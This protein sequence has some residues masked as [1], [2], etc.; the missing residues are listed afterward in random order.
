MPWVFRFICFLVFVFFTDVCLAQVITPTLSISRTSGPAPLGVVVSCVG[1]S[2]SDPNVDTIREIYCKWDYGDPTSGTWVDGKSRNED[3]GLVSGHVYDNPG[4][5]TITLT[6]F[7]EAGNQAVTTQQI[8]ADDPLTYYQPASTYCFSNGTDFSFCPYTTAQGA[9]H[10]TTND[11]GVVLSYSG[12][13]RRLILRSGD[14]FVYPSGVGSIDMLGDN[15]ILQS[16]DPTNP[17]SFFI[18]GY[19]CAS[20]NSLV[21]PTG[22]NVTIYGIRFYGPVGNDCSGI[23]ATTLGQDDWADTLPENNLVVYKCE[24]TELDQFTIAG[25]GNGNLFSTNPWQIAYTSGSMFVDNYM[26]D[27]DC[28]NGG[29]QY[30]IYYLVN[31]LFAIIGNRFHNFCNGTGGQHVIRGIADREVVISHN[32][33]INCEGMPSTQRDCLKIHSSTLSDPNKPGQSDYVMI[34]DNIFKPGPYTVWPLAVSAQN[35]FSEELV[36]N[37]IFERNYI[38]VLDNGADIVLLWSVENGAVRNNVAVTAPNDGDVRVF[39]I[40]DDSGTVTATGSWVYNNTCIMDSP[41]TA[42]RAHCVVVEPAHTG[43]VVVGNLMQS[44]GTSV[45][46]DLSGSAVLEGNIMTTNAGVLVDPPSRIEEAKL[47]ESSPAI[48]FYIPSITRN[49]FDAGG[50]IRPVDGPDAD[51]TPQWDAGAWEYGATS[52]KKNVKFRRRGFMLE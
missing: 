6:V 44:S 48:D 12:T 34:Y 29:G 39:F 5:Y 3:M 43:A 52:S 42:S 11:I 36:A 8:V 22:Q 10:V 16:S 23:N 33:F 19:S 38:N 1:S 14:T 13:D 26:H 15:V 41:S 47:T 30:G 27:I 20:S 40:N 17:A 50:G 37:S 4:T 2:H 51:S 18:S 24:F 28:D 9:T 49:R 31:R 46:S 21:E 7:D 25:F 35:S 32:E 45:V